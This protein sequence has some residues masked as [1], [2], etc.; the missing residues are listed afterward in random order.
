MTRITILTKLRFV[1]A[2][3]PLL[4][5]IAAPVLAMA[6]YVF[7]AMP[8]VLNGDEIQALRAAH[9]MELALYKMDWG[10][11]QPD[12]MQI[13][14]DQQRR[15]VNWV[16]VARDHVET[17]AQY[18][19]LGRI[20]KTANPIFTAMRKAQPGDQSL[21]PDLVKLQG[22]V[23]DLS[24][25]DDA[26][27]EDVASRAH[28]RA[29][30]MIVVVVV[31]G[32][33]VPWGCFAIVARLCGGAQIALRDI[34]HRVDDLIDRAGEPNEDLRAIDERMTELGFARRNPMLAE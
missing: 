25:A 17:R 26:V 20:A 2:L 18:D 33:I 6:F 11:T 24:S 4:M 23:N 10:R 13:V 30:V 5:V 27:L 12:G 19:A 8:T 3:A 16:S 32:F 31:A 28:T 15:F 7:G 14:Q 9:G 29:T 21:E 22:L 34:R 1:A